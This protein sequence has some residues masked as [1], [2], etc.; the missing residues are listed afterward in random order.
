MSARISR[1]TLNSIMMLGLVA[2]MSYSLLG[3]SVH[4]WVG[5]AVLVCFIWHLLRNR[6]WFSALRRGRYT[7]GRVVG[8]IVNGLILVTVLGLCVSSLMLSKYVF[9]FLPLSLP[10]GVGQTPHQV[11]AYW[12]FLLMAVHL[13]W[14]G[15]A[16]AASVTQRVQLPAWCWRAALLCV[17]LL[18]AASAAVQRFPAHLFM[19]VRG[20]ELENGLLLFLIGEAALFALCACA[21]AACKRFLQMKKGDPACH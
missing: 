13:G 10:E 11:C 18:G 15:R 12:G 17:V 4:E 20:F 16:L 21:G 7:G 14:H 3:E 6:G 1:W 8:S 2:S 9:A 5:T 19:Q